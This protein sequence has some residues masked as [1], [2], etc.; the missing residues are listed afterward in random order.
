[1]RMDCIKIKKPYISGEYANVYNPPPDTYKGIDSICFKKDGFYE[2]WTANDFT[3]IKGMDDKWHIIGITHPSPDGFEDEFSFDTDTVHDAEWQLFHCV[4]KN[5]LLKDNIF[6]GAFIDQQKILYPQDRIGEPNECWAPCVLFKD[7]RYYL[8][9]SP[10]YMRLAKSN[11]L[12]D[13]DIMGSVFEGSS[14]MRDPFIYY[15]ASV[16][17]M[18]YVEDN[19][20]MRTSTNLF[21][22]SERKLFQKCPYPGASQESPFVF[23]KDNIYY[24][25]WCIYDGFNGC[26]DNRTFVFASETLD[27]FDGK[28]PITMLKSHASEIIM[29]EDG[30]YYIFSA[31]Y[32]Y[33][34]VNVAK[35]EWEY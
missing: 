34:G 28:A 2:K 15:E 19:L 25:S 21:D 12:F 16:Y 24:L 23:K 26:Y 9:Y 31:Y 8:F 7:Y 30:E 5:S 22:W 29:D 27:G 18:I 17:Y 14:N 20:Y 11:N 3:V 4:S 10:K 13:W 1:M 33:N 32:P 35:I 6:N